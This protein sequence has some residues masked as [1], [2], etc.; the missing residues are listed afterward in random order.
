MRHRIQRWYAFAIF[1]LR[2]LLRSDMDAGL[3]QWKARTIITASESFF[4]LAAIDEVSIAADW[5]VFSTGAFVFCGV[6]V[7]TVFYW[8]NGQAEERLLPRFERDFRKLSRAQRIAGTVVVLLLVV[9]SGWAAL[10][11][12][13][14]TH[15]AIIGAR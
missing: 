2:E 1:L 10:A 9:A 3:S 8:A 5:R 4:A 15:N 12:G 7:S 13:K 6:V 14:A 11:S